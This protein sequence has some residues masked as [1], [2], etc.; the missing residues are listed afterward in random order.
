M[1]FRGVG[2]LERDPSDRLPPF[3]PPFRGG[4][5]AGGELGDGLDHGS[6]ITEAELDGCAR[7]AAVEVD[8]GRRPGD[9]R[10]LLL[11]AGDNYFCRWRPC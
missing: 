10:Q 8:H 6:E 4:E 3:P 5:T 1:L 11:P 9:P 2:V 7:D